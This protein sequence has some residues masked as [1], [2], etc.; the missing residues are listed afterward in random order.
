MSNIGI[1]RR[2]KTICRWTDADELENP[3]KSMMRLKKTKDFIKVEEYKINIQ[4]S[5]TRT[6][7]NKTRK[8]T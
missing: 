8:D 7:T 5:I 6:R 1:K 4:K 3:G 2:N